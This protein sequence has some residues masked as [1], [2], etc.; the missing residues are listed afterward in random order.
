[1]MGDIDAPFPS[2]FFSKGLDLLFLIIVVSLF[3]DGV[4]AVSF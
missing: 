2:M 4:D 3:M 1:M